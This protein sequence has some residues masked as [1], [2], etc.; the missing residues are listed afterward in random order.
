MKGSEEYAGLLEGL[1]S[2]IV[3]WFNVTGCWLVWRH[4]LG[5]MTSRGADPVSSGVWIDDA[6]RNCVLKRI[7]AKIIRVQTHFK[8]KFAQNWS[9]L[10]LCA[11]LQ[12]V[13][14]SPHLYCQDLKS[15]E[16]EN[17]DR[18]ATGCWKVNVT[19]P[20]WGSFR[21]RCVDRWREKKIWGS[22]KDQFN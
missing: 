5:G 17:V 14:H 8:I 11:G 19:G 15:W 18:S 7:K 10:G 3:G 21:Y 4:R 20:W 16:M 6:R 1:T 9:N 2:Q 22:G 12:W 13:F